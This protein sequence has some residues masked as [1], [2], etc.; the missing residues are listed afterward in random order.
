VRS[1]IAAP[2]LEPTVFL[3]AAVGEVVAELRDAPPRGLVQA[4]AYEAAARLLQACVDAAAQERTALEAQPGAEG[5]RA[6]R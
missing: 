3:A 1:E 6:E 4:S 2:A 5:P